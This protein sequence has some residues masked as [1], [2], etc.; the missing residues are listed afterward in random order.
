[1]QTQ[2]ILHDA[3]E[4]AYYII[5]EILTEGAEYI[6][7]SYISEKSVPYGIKQ[8]IELMFCTLES[9]YSRHEF[10]DMNSWEEDS[11]PKPCGIDTWARNAIPT[12]KK[13]KMIPPQ[14][15]L[16]LPADAKSIKSHRSVR[17]TRS[18]IG[19]RLKGQTVLKNAKDQE[20]I[21]EAPQA[22][23]LTQKKLMITEEEEELRIKKLKEE[24]EEK[25]KKIKKESGE[26]KNKVF[27]Y[28]NNGNIL[29]V[30]QLKYDEIPKIFTEIELKPFEVPKEVT[31]TFNIIKTHPKRHV[32]EANRLKTA[33]VRDQEWVRNI[34]SVGPAIFDTI[35]LN[36]GVNIA[37]G[38]HLKYAPSANASSMK[39][40]TRREYNLNS[41]M[42]PKNSTNSLSDKK[43][44]QASSQNSFRKSSMV[45]SK[46]DILEEIAD[47]DDQSDKIE[48]EEDRNLVLPAYNEE[49]YH[50]KI[51]YY[52][53]GYQYTEETPL[54]KF[55]ADILK[56][57]SWGTNPG[58]RKPLIQ[59]KLPR[60]PS[61]RE[62]R[63]IYGDI[64][65]KPKDQPFITSKELWDTNANRLKKPRDR[66][67]LEK[68]D[69]KTKLPPPPYG[70]TMINALPSYE[71]LIKTNGNLVLK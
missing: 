6:Y 32:E 1:M 52:G 9:Y 70:Y 62:L 11:E 42:P 10:T 66:P 41:L 54:N 69:R 47:Y 68:V 28:D 2:E 61:S 71:E 24:L 65:K 13:F 8:S 50:G 46:K 39:Q 38:S 21:G 45:S 44:Q 15:L 33:P 12:Q 26:M 19:K 4:A 14:P 36:P 16:Q 58:I 49:K 40:L 3:F 67:Y 17:S 22:F 27:T 34:T 59:E 29:F 30:N 53:A 23:P 57:K 5:D 35:K 20:S 7:S 51:T 60:K 43:S 56:N 25:E 18:A 37:D 31:T 48:E 55:N 63:Q 64:L